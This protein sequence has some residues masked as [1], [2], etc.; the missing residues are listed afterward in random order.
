MSV[1]EEDG[2]QSPEEFPY[3]KHGMSVTTTSGGSKRI[4]VKVM[5]IASFFFMFASDEES[6]LE[7]KKL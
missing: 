2:E 7:R 6:K 4:S 3:E 5:I 1:V